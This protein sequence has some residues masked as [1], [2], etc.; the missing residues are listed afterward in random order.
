MVNILNYTHVDQYK[1]SGTNAWPQTMCLSKH[2]DVC[3]YKP[4]CYSASLHTH[5]LNYKHAISIQIKSMW[6]E[7]M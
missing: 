3:E 4:C 1:Q 7:S 5:L 2:K 6:L